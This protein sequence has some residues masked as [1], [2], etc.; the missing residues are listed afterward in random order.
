MR[1]ALVLIRHA[2]LDLLNESSVMC[3]RRSRLPRVRLTMRL[4]CAFRG[5]QWYT[6]TFCAAQLMQYEWKRRTLWFLAQYH[7]LM[8]FRADRLS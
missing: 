1:T 3:A 8:P 7:S 2:C 5:A 6:L 4:H